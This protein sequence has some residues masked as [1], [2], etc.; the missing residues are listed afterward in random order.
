MGT[1]RTSSTNQFDRLSKNL[2]E[3]QGIMKILLPNPYL[4]SGE[5][6]DVEDRAAARTSVAM[7]LRKERVTIEVMDSSDTDGRIKKA[8]FLPFLNRFLRE[9]KIW[10]RLYRIDHGKYLLPFYGFGQRTDLRLYKVS[11]WPVHGNALAYVKKYDTKVRYRRMVTDIAQGIRVLHLEMKPPVIHGGIRAE[12]IFIGRGGNPM[13]GDFGFPKV[14]SNMTNMSF[15]NGVDDSLYRWCAPE[16]FSASG[17]GIVSPA[18]DVYSF[19]M[20]ILELFTHQY[21]YYNIARS[22]EV[23]IN[24]S[25]GVAPSRPTE[26]SVIKRGLDDG[27]WQLL[28][29]CWSKTPSARPSIEE[30]LKRLSG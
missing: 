6:T 1:L 5:I 28:V 2:Y 16:I 12:N 10:E 14:E 26:S 18:S 8:C 25:R 24:V 15:D 27:I 20:T 17:I 9:A 13:I 30:I 29:E 19:S 4:A 7:Y 21:P 22:T 11:R 23:A 3:L